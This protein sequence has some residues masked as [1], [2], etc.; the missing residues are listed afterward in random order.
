MSVPNPRWDI[1]REIWK[2]SLGDYV[3]HAGIDRRAPYR[4]HEEVVPKGFPAAQ[5]RFGMDMY[6]S[7]LSFN[8]PARKN[9]NFA[10]SSLLFADLDGSSPFRIKP[11]PTWAWE[12]SPGSYQAAWF[13]NKVIM[14]YDEWAHLNKR[15]TIHTNA[16]VGGWQGSKLLRVPGTANFKRATQ[17]EIPLGVVKIH[18]EAEIDHAWLEKNLPAVAAPSRAAVNE[19][20]LPPL[21][22]P[23]DRAGLMRRYWPLITLRGRDMLSKTKVSD[24]SL[25]IVRTIHELLNAGLD[26]AAVFHL[27]WVQPWNKWRTDRN[28]PERLWEE[29]QLA[30]K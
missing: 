14:A 28:N 3:T 16:D 4:F 24:R 22:M 26:P 8:Q 30:A 18:N 1:V 20:W 13:M 19:N 10:G 5:Q 21:A 2:C 9:E 29:I 27:I 6:F 7:A 12:T 15:M 23:E 17:F 25:H 11:A